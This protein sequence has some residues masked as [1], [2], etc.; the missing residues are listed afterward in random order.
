[1]E[2]GAERGRL[3]DY[4]FGKTFTTGKSDRAF[5]TLDTL[6]FSFADAQE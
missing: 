3:I 6:P 1:M 4:A 2:L 5:H